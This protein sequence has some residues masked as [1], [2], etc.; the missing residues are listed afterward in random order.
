MAQVAGALHASQFNKIVYHESHDEAGANTT[1]RTMVVAVN[2]ENPSSDV[3][4]FAEARSRVCFGLSLLSAGTPMFFM[5]EEIGAR[6]RFTVDDFSPEDLHGERIGAGAPMFRFYQEAIAFSRRRP[7]ARSRHIDVIYAW[8][9][10]RVVAFTRRS[11]QDELLVVASLN[12]AP[13]R[14]GY[15]ITQPD[16]SRL[17]DGS[18][19]EVFN[20]DA[21][22]YGGNNVGNFG[23]AVPARGG[24][25]RV[26][27]PANGFLIFQK[28]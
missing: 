9:Q 6:R 22:I 26:R 24:H 7:A 12:N 14:D 16:T 28:Q 3:R 4:R 11:G 17:P 23:A 2:Q 10:T 20:S 27:L 18:W 8:D 13:F 25:I 5:G 19:R 21:A 1:R 15:S